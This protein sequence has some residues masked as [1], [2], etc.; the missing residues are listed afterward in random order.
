M[1]EGGGTA[2]RAAGGV[3]LQCVC[4]LRMEHEQQDISSTNMASTAAPGPRHTIDAIL[5]LNRG[6]HTSSRQ[7]LA[8]LSL[9]LHHLVNPGAVLSPYSPGIPTRRDHGHESSGKY[10]DLLFCL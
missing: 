7:N 10:R 6:H 8:P 4:A 5:G 9:A 3:P 2:A 1:K